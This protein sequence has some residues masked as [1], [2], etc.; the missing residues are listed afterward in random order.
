MKQPQKQPNSDRDTTL[1]EDI[2]R[3]GGDLS[4][5]TYNGLR[6]VERGI[7]YLIS[8]H[9]HNAIKHNTSKNAKSSSR[10]SLH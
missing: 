4:R 5:H 7:R 1:Q 2:K 6:A 8:K 9:P 3:F 10:R